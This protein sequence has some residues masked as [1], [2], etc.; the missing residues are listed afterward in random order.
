MICVIA[1]SK[2][3]KFL[4]F[5]GVVHASLLEVFSK[6]WMSLSKVLKPLRF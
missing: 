1:P 3:S 4:A 6:D 5:F 2:I